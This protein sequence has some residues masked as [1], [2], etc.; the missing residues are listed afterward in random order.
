MS[1]NIL[2][3][4]VNAVTG[5][6]THI[7]NR[8]RQESFYSDGSNTLLETG[9]AGVSPDLLNLRPGQKFLITS[10]VILF[11]VW[12]L[13]FALGGA[14]QSYLYNQTIGTNGFLTIIYMIL[15][16]MFPYFYYPFYTF[17]LHGGVNALPS[18]TGQY[19]GKRR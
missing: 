14:L 18:S 11:I 1:S 9:K 6:A 3:G 16:F 19:G 8:S 4:Y 12:Q 15:C 5:V 7:V 13:I 10:I 17:F 2:G